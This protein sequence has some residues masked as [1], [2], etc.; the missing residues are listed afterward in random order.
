V[1]ETYTILA[2]PRTGGRAL[3][4]RPDV[5]QATRMHTIRHAKLGELQWEEDGWWEGNAPIGKGD[6]LPF[7][8]RGDRGGPDEQLAAALAATLAKWPDIV[9]KSRAFLVEACKKARANVSAEDFSI[10]SIVFL[11]TPHHFAI[12]L[13][14]DRDQESIWKLEFENGEPANLS[15]DD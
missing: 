1:P 6:E 14:C 13:E 9:K 10:L 15:R 8:V 3:P 11:S 12:D 2:D 5:V 7:A 4:L